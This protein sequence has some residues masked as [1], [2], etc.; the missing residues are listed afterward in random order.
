MLRQIVEKHVDTSVHQPIV[1]GSRA[2]GVARKYSDID[3]GFLNSEPLSQTSLDRL[4]DDVEESDLPF[5]VDIVD[6]SKVEDNF[7]RIALKS[8]ERI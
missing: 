7:R 2:K 3:L 4:T 5:K 6:F 8:Y 1:F